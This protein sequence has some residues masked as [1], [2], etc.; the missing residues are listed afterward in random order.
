MGH[1]KGWR[2]VT[3]KCQG[4]E[5]EKE[6]VMLLYFNLKY[7][8]KSEWITELGEILS[9]KKIVSQTFFLID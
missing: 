5:K 9:P 1:G 3:Q 2:E 8:L 6:E 4:Q 7:V